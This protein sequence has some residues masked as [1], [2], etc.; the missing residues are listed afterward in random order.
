MIRYLFQD[1]VNNRGQVK[2]ILILVFFRFVNLFARRR[3]SIL[4]WLGIPFMIAYRVMVEY[5]L[6]VE[7]RASTSVG[8]GLKIEHGYALVINDRTVIGRNV[9]V[10]HC[11][12]IGCVKLADGSQG[13]SPV[14]GDNVEVGAN[15]VI[16]GGIQV[17]DYA[18]IGAGSVVISNVPAYATVVGNPARVIKV[19]DGEKRLAPSVYEA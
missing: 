13:P 18:R 5:I 16:L 17:G 10:R 2:I 7:L 1:Y 12:T 4:W 19:A 11:T 15:S 8:A 9:H 14:I 6:C 3:G